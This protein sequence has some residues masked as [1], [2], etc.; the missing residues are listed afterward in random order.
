MVT[1]MFISISISILV[2]VFFLSQGPPEITFCP[3]P[4]LIR[5][6]QLIQLS[7]G[8]YGN[9]FMVTT[10]LWLGVDRNLTIRSIFPQSFAAL[11]IC[12]IWKQNEVEKTIYLLSHSSL[13]LDSNPD[14][15]CS[16]RMVNQWAVTLRHRSWSVWLK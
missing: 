15:Q 5:L 13:H 11:Q 16:K 2:I 8:C 6:F 1:Y 4:G 12:K 9:V 10:C 14:L 3:R 7:L